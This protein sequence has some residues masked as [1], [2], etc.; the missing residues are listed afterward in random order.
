LSMHKQVF[1]FECPNGAELEK[2]LHELDN[3]LYSNPNTKRPRRLAVIINPIGGHGKAKAEYEK[4][5]KPLFKLAGIHL[6]EIE[7]QR[8][9]HVYEIIERLD[10]SLIDGIVSVGGDGM[11]F[12]IVN[13]LM[14]RPDKEAINMPLGLIP[15]GSQNALAVSCSGH[16]CAETHALDIIK[17]RRMPMDI[18]K[19]HHKKTDQYIYSNIVTAFGF[20]GDVGNTSQDYRHLGPFRYIYCGAMHLTKPKFYTI[21]LRYIPH[22]STSNDDW[23]ELEENIFSF[24][25]C[26]LS[27]ANTQFPA[28]CPQAHPTDGCLSL[29]V[30]KK[31]SRFQMFKF[32]SR[33][34]S[35]THHKLPYVQMLKVRRL[36]FEP[37]TQG[38]FLNIDG[39]IFESSQLDFE[40]QPSF[41]TLMCAPPTVL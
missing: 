1:T 8:K 19:V 30:W 35:G 7:T 18:V 11:F 41:L 5:A 39:E 15:A 17:G 29:C 24:M 27:C 23:Q 22:D 3:V 33:H 37:I 9:Q 31:C 28:L 25:A 40:L 34:K 38:S 4:R 26:N 16:I 10:L 32:S 36:R 6:L 12:E 21:K 13:G 2:F 14:K 20:M